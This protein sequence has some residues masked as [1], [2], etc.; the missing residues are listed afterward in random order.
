MKHISLGVL[1]NQAL[2]GA[3]LDIQPVVRMDELFV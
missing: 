2:I 3:C 1:V